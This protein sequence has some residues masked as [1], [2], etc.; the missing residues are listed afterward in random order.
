MNRLWSQ[1]LRKDLIFKEV[2][3]MMAGLPRGFKIAK[4]NN[5]LQKANRIKF[6][7]RSN[8]ILISKFTNKFTNLTN[9]ILIY[10]LDKQNTYCQARVLS[11]LVPAMIASVI[12]NIPKFLEARLEEVF[13]NKKI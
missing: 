5:V 3:F 10:K 11:Y 6:K 1:I 2:V 13:H 12:L 7:I 4:N 8:K 9:K